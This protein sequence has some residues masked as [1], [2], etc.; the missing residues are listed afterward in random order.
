MNFDQVSFLLLCIERG[1]KVDFAG[2]GEDYEKIHG[3]KLSANAAYKRFIRLK[4]KMESEGRRSSS[5][6]SGGKGAKIDDGGI[7]MKKRKS[8]GKGG[9]EKKAKMEVKEDADGDLSAK[10]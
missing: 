6:K 8:V 3:E 7:E 9:T 2:V 1:G 4:K 10:E 5:S